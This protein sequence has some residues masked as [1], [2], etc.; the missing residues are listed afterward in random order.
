M[1]KIYFALFAIIVM[2]ASGCEGF[3]DENPKS[4]FIGVEAYS[5]PK[6]VYINCVAS[7]YVP[8]TIPNLS[9][10]DQVLYYFDNCAADM[11]ITPGRRNGWVDGG[12]H[13]QIFQH[14]ID[15][16]FGKLATAW[17]ACYTYIALCNRSLDQVKQILEDGGDPDILNPYISEISILRDIYYMVALDYW[18]RI[19]IV[20][21][22]SMSIADVKQ[23]SRSEA[24]AWL[25][26]DVST[27]IPE[28][29]SALS[30]RTG[31]FYGRMTK[32]IGYT[33]LMK[34][35]LNSPIWSLDNWENSPYIAEVTKDNYPE[36]H[37]FADTAPV[38]DG[39]GRDDDSI[40]FP[41]DLIKT[42]RYEYNMDGV[43]DKVTAAGKQYSIKCPDGTSR[44]AWETVI[45]CQEQVEKEGYKLA[46]NYGDNFTTNNDATSP[47][48][49]FVMPMDEI[50]RFQSTVFFS[51]NFD[52]AKQ[53]GISIACNGPIST[54]Q[55]A[56][57][58][59]YD[60]DTM[61]AAD[62]RM[63]QTV[64]FGVQKGKD[65]SPLKSTNGTGFNEQLVY[66][67]EYSRLDYQESYAGAKWDYLFTYGGPRGG[68]KRDWDFSVSN[69]AMLNNS[70]RVVWRY[71][72]CVLAAAEA[73][74]RL[75]DEGKCVEMFNKIRTRAGV[76]TYAAVK[77]SNLLDE[78]AREFA[79]EYGRRTD[80]IRF[81]MFT[82]P[83]DDKFL[84]VPAHTLGGK[85]KDD[86]T[87][88][89]TV[90]PIPI[91]V[92]QLNA[93]MS[94]NPWKKGPWLGWK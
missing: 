26:N 24:L 56:R 12:P 23:S 55:Y 69:P 63:A 54:I 39:K 9:E 14:D 42:G 45:W 79:W 86:P 2:M 83:T 57:L 77:P 1:K 27:L 78:R 72:D 34:L 70:D 92:L 13:Q 28:L 60:P 20:E 29:P 35:A 30:Q 17:N 21:S 22:G 82:L 41:K 11:V 58:N 31:E 51:M 44:N 61:T 25:I 10:F 33:L 8:N 71:A 6:L 16:T 62:P 15:E 48:N 19:P 80:L 64:Y 7:L 93:N 18:G 43:F 59:G 74:K 5:N 67:P 91:S 66:F 47:E 46:T 85:Y 4:A 65:G 76:E 38:V 73:Y 37:Q 50:T 84:G 32:A 53:I 89:T 90:Y 3:L 81:G 88:I 68:K 49:I 75:G 52:H 40:I 94:Q 36:A 87:G